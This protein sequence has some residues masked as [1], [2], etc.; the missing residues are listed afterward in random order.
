MAAQDCDSNKPDDKSP[1]A[2]TGPRAR[3]PGRSCRISPG[4]RPGTQ[5]NQVLV[6]LGKAP[7]AEEFSG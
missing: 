7:G 2:R 4:D 5:G 1:A 6:H 3:H